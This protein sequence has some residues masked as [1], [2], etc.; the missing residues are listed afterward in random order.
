MLLI[1]SFK[2]GAR[3]Q[4]RFSWNFRLVTVI[5]RHAPWVLRGTGL[6]LRRTRDTTHIPKFCF[7]R[8]R[9]QAAGG[10]DIHKHRRCS[11]WCGVSGGCGS[12]GARWLRG[13][14]GTRVHCDLAAPSL[15]RE[16]FYPCSSLGR[17]LRRQ[18]EI[19]AVS[20]PSVSLS[21]LSPKQ[22]LARHSG[23]WWGPPLADHSL[24]ILSWLVTL[25]GAWTSLPT[26]SPFWASLC[27]HHSLT[28]K[29]S[30]VLVVGWTFSCLFISLLIWQC[31][32]PKPRCTGE[33]LLDFQDLQP[34]RMT[35]ALWT[36]L[37]P[38]LP[39]RAPPSPLLSSPPPTPAP[40]PFKGPPLFTPLSLTFSLSPH[41]L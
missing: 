30:H 14:W 22:H 10:A 29:K 2:C 41:L 8:S 33:P 40:A 12:S 31:C 16:N 35:S 7:Q 34:G 21:P 13:V 17:T 1:L 19:G 28:R 32:L 36:P 4:Q 23:P 39:L 27:R 37:C 20:R 38:W 6:W 18:S 26:L 24:P 5:Q 3:R 11:G 9:F 15:V 25:G